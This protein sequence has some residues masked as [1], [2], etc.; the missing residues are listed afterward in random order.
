MRGAAK[1]TCPDLAIH[2]AYIVRLHGS[3]VAFAGSEQRFDSSAPSTKF[4]NV[5]NI[6][7]DDENRLGKFVVACD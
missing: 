4:P 7:S 1:T 5:K 6:R 2:F 3:I